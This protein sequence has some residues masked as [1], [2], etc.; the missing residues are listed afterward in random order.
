LP[1]GKAPDEFTNLD[2]F[3]DHLMSDRLAFSQRNAPLD[4]THIEIAAADHEGTH[5]GFQP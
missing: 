3:A 4:E 1:D 5:Q 2:D